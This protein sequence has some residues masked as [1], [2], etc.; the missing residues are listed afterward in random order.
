MEMTEDE[1]WR[2]TARE[3]SEGPTRQVKT[4]RPVFSGETTHPVGTVLDIQEEQAKALCL[5]GAAKAV[6][7]AVVWFQEIARDIAKKVKPAPPAEPVA[8]LGKPSSDAD[9]G[10]L[11]MYKCETIGAKGIFVK[12]RTF[13]GTLYLSEAD[14]RLYSEARV[15]KLIDPKVLP[16]LPEPKFVVRKSERPNDTTVTLVPA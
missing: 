12:N 13:T 2:K 5:S 6:G 3:L 14:A 15:V 9:M 1:K 10:P 16:A 8:D 4:E 7:S 11:R